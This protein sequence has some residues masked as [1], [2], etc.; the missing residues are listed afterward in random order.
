[1]TRTGIRLGLAVVGVLVSAS[2]VQAQDAAA[3]IAEASRMIGATELNSITYSGNAAQ[4]NF[5]QSRT[6]TF[7]IASTS[8]RNYTRTID[9]TTSTALITGD[10]MPPVVRGGPPPQPGQLRQLIT[11]DAPWSL[12]LQ[13]WVTP[14]GFLRGAAANRA[15]RALAENRWR[16]VPSR[17][18][19][20][21]AEGAIGR[22]IQAG[23]LHRRQ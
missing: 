5:G 10:T 12:Q 23:G 7:G 16:A 22:A 18:V 14:W 19:D 4:G 11:A 1:M 9:F 8:I 2:A 13:I 17:D 15:T 20:D 3:V 21:A 6:I